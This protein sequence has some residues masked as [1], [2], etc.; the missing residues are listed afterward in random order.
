V[1]FFTI[2]QADTAGAWLAVDTRAT[3]ITKEETG[4]RFSLLIW[5]TRKF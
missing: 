4:L 5:I 3:L 2:L 1:L